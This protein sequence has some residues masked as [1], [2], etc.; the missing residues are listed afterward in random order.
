[1]FEVEQQFQWLNRDN[2][3]CIVLTR[4]KGNADFIVEI[5]VTRY[6]PVIG[7]DTG[8]DE[9]WG[10]A[11]LS[12]LTRNGDLLLNQSYSQGTGRY[13]ASDDIATQPIK[14]AGKALCGGN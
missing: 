5:S 7:Y 13:R 12:I 14:G 9:L 10:D 1:M 4:N 6:Q 2:P 11:K 3:S 8:Q